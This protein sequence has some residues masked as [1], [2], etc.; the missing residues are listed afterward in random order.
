MR[1]NLL[2]ILYFVVCLTGKA[3]SIQSIKSTC[4][5]HVVRD[6]DFTVVKYD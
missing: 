4:H 5:Y 6:I 2:E 3:R 1:K